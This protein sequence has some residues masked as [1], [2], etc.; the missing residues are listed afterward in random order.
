[1]T[2]TQIASKEVWDLAAEFGCSYADALAIL[3][4]EAAYAASEQP[5]FNKNPPSAWDEVLA[6]G[7]SD[8]SSITDRA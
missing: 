5:G 8:Q 1:M 4:R 6:E 2:S 3:K 7:R